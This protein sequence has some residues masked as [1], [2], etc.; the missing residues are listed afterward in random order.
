MT[1]CL[2]RTPLY[3]AHV[4][5]G[6]KLVEFA[7]W[8]MP[9]QYGGIGLEHAAVRNAAGLFD[10]SHMGQFQVCGPEAESFLERLLPAPV[11]R[12]RDGYMLYTPMCNE[13]GGCVDDLLVYRQNPQSFLLVVNAGQTAIDWEWICAQKEPNE[14]VDLADLSV[15]T[16]MLALQGPSASAIIASGLPEGHEKQLGY[17]RFTQT[18]LFGYRVI[19]SRNGYTGEDGFE[20]MCPW[21]EAEPIWSSLLS[22][23]GVPCGLGAR[24]TL[25]TEMGFALYG[26]E[27]SVETTPY[28]AGIGWTVH[29]KKAVPFVG[30]SSLERIQR[31]GTHRLLGGLLMIDRGIPRPGYTVESAEGQAVGVVCSGTQSPTLQRGIGLAQLDREAHRLGG[32]LFVVVR[33]RR[34]KAKVVKLPFVESKVKKS[35]AGG[36]NGCK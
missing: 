15:E 12:L 32:E 14:K 3:D 28:E 24:D 13:A 22:A 20:I 11:H 34:L 2:K 36:I 26:H 33:G 4:R 31:E 29:L 16:A 18:T 9:V 17:Y 1:E 30:K 25:R 21:E 10:V 5:S 6:G 23:G 8:E 35:T 27:L 19:L 7:G